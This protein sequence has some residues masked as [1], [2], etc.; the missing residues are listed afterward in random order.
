MC[1]RRTSGRTC[2]SWRPRREARAR[3]RHGRL[4]RH[5]RPPRRQPHP[6]GRE[7]R[8]PP[9]PHPGWQD[10]A[11]PVGLAP[12][13]VEEVFAPV[14]SLAAHRVSVLLVE[15]YVAKALAAADLV[16]ILDRGRIVF[17]GEP[18]EAS[19]MDVAVRYLGAEA[20]LA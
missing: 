12:V 6:A 14:R 18:D 8:G 15:Q 5:D 3:P 7:D 20:A 13:V 1:R 10:D 11:P 17:A 9:R 2:P 4:R 16:Y 19:A